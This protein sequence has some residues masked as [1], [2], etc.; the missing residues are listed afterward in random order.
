[1]ISDVPQQLG[2][3]PV[4]PTGP[5]SPPTV[6]GLLPAAQG[7]PAQ[8]VAGPSPTPEQHV[9]ALLGQFRDLSTS[10]Q[11]LARQYP[12]AAQD[13]SVANDALI[14]AMTKIVSSMSAESS[15]APAMLA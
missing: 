12:A 2:Q 6:Q 10:V 7:A 11:G 9:E 4:G 8:G 5:T 1:M 15:S 13:L 3:G 14:N